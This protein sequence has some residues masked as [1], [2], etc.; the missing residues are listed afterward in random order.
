VGARGN[1]PDLRRE[2][3]NPNGLNLAIWM[4]WVFV[5][6]GSDSLPLLPFFG[7]VLPLL[8]R[9]IFLGVLVLRV[10]GILALLRFLI[11]V[12]VLVLLFTLLV[13]GFAHRGT[14]SMR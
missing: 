8:L 14:P 6:R 3:P 1:P 4:F 2:G 11:L 13:L 5:V 12:T 10:V 9:V 7:I